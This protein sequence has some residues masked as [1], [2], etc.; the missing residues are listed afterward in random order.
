[1]VEFNHDQGALHW[2][3]TLDGVGSY[4]GTYT[5]AAG[6]TRYDVYLRI[7][8]EVLAAAGRAD[9]LVPPTLFFDLQPNVL[10]VPVVA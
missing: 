8:S 3:L 6:E 9:G 1:M 4:S 2:C 7:R 5:P 10:A